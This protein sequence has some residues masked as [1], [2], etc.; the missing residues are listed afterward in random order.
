MSKERAMY[1]ELH[2]RESAGLR[3]GIWI[4]SLGRL[5]VRVFE[6]GGNFRIAARDGHDALEKFWHPYLYLP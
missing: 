4:D 3:V 2:T 5:S 1:E 6:A